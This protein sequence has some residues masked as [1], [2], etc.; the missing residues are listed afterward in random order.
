MSR[1]CEVKNR[2]SSMAQN[3]ASVA[4]IAYMWKIGTISYSVIAPALQNIVKRAY[5]KP[6]IIWTTMRQ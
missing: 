1:G 3:D 2:Q 4:Y 6:L 5:E